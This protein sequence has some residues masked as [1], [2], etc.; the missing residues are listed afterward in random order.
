MVIANSVYQ[1]TVFGPP[2]WNSF[3]ADVAIPASSTGGD[4]G[5]FAD[6]LNVFQQFDQRVPLDEIKATLVKCQ[7]KCIAGAK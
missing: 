7:K 2:L 5:M 1:G 4:E 6:D 3:F